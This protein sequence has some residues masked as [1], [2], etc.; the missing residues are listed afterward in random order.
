M[1]QKLIVISIERIFYWVTLWQTSRTRIINWITY[2]LSPW[3][4]LELNAYVISLVHMIYIPWRYKYYPHPIL[5]GL[6]YN[7]PFSNLP[8]IHLIH[9]SIQ[10]TF[11]VYKYWLSNTRH[12]FYIPLPS[13]SSAIMLLLVTY[14]RPYLKT[15]P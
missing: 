14:Y 15:I 8:L 6:L 2:S 9:S 1:R 11:E 13:F 7:V 5:N 4:V 12:Y 10:I 3:E